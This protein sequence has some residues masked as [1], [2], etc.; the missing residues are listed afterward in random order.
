MM[1]IFGNMKEKK[2]KKKDA[3]VIIKN[4]CLQLVTNEQIRFTFDLKFEIQNVLNDI[5]NNRSFFPMR[6]STFGPTYSLA[7]CTIPKPSQFGFGV[8]K[9]TKF[10]SLLKL[11]RILELMN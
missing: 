7:G 10:S 1:L 6:V 4:D 11:K 9:F 2:R 5:T 3:Y 8:P